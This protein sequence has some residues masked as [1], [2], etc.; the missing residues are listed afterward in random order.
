MGYI[1]NLSTVNSTNIIYQ[2][3]EAFIKKF[4]TNELLRGTLLF[5]GFG[6]LY[7]LF[8]LFIEYFLWLQPAARTFLFWTFVGVEVYLFSRF[9]AFPLFKLFK[10]QKGIS[11]RE[12]STIIGNHFPEVKDK[13]LNYIQLSQNTVDQSE[14]LLASI[15]QKSDNLAPIPFGKAINFKSNKR[16]LP[17]A[18]I[19]LL[20]LFAFFVSGNSTIISQSLDRVIHYKA[21]FVKPAPFQLVI[22]NRNL[23]VQENKDFVLSVKT[24]GAVLPENVMLTIGDESYFMENSGPG[25]FQYKFVAPSSDVVFHLEANV[26]VSPSFTLKVIDVPSISSFEMFLHFP[27][28]LN[29]KS[30]VVKGTGNAVIPEGT[31]VNWKIVSSS[32]ESIVFNEA[33]VP[34]SFVSQSNIFNF[35]KIINQNTDYQVIT[36][37]SNVKYF[38][39]LNYQLAIV[40]DQYPT[41]DVEQAPDSLKVDKRFF[42]GKIGDDY[43]FSKLQIVYYEKGKPFTSKRGTLP[44]KSGN[45]DQ[46]VFSFPGNLP[47]R[48]GISYDFYFEIFDNDA[49]HHF[50]STRSIVFSNRVSTASEKEDALIEEQNSTL[51]S[52]EKTLQKQSKQFSDLDKLNKS[53]KEK[54]ELEFKDQQMVNDFIKRQSQQDQLMKSFSEKIKEN[55][56]QDNSQNKDKTKE[57]LEKRLDKVTSAIDKNKQLLDELKELND[58]LNNEDL[59]DKLQQFKQNSKNQVKT[60]EQ[61]VELTKRYY[62]DKKA[63]QIAEKL[64]KLSNEQNK[65]SKDPATESK[66][67]DKINDEFKSLEE[68]LNDVLKENKSLKS[69]MDLP[70]TKDLQQDI[71]QDLNSAKE[72]LGKRN[73]SKAQSSQKNAS[74]KMKKMSDKLKE[75]MASGEQEQLQEDIKMLRQ[76]LDNLLAFSNSQEDVMKQFKSTKVGSSTYNKYLK[77]QQTLKTQFKHVDDSLFAMSLRNPKIAE[78][79][80]KEIGTVQYNLDNAIDKLGNGIV[81]K[82][83]S[84]QQFSV[85]SA[86]KLADF[87]SEQ[88]NNMQMD[89][90]GMSSG[91]P[92]PGHG[93]G[94]Q[95]PDIM[96]KQKGL[97]EK[98]QQQ[99][100]GEG[101]SK[102]GSKPGNKPDSKYTQG[103]EG[104]GGEGDAKSIMEIYKEQKQL[105]DALQNELNKNGLNGVGQNALEQMKQ[106]EKQLLNK[107]FKNEVLQRILNLNQE[108][109][110]LDNALQQ[111]G[112]DTKRQSETNLKGFNN[113]SKGL[114][115]NLLQYINSVEIL[116]RQSLPLR[117]NF[118]QK[119]QEYFNKND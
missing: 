10:L 113:T 49:V 62:V 41:I 33:R 78:D 79:V 114:P 108:L 118:N 23:V 44:S 5:I 97:G 112:Q 107:G 38:E 74:Q 111:Q 37:N 36:S 21:S 67:Q 91:N 105:R 9:I 72:Q 34:S 58:K 119:V 52:L 39:K 73:S 76:I 101:K 45:F 86:N 29:R 100:K 106:I 61:L 20:F 7:F 28:Y 11:Y 93:K 32:T 24:I 99:M 22:Q 17:I 95:L 110:K 31:L 117:S 94:M 25:Q 16:Y 109:L 115:N 2:K 6:L 71:K 68:Q 19:P 26:V 55:L 35:K 64:D 77:T 98:M 43:G 46:F 102:G 15:Q 59:Q 88:L 40:K 103:E 47:L 92:K 83:V 104:P 90:S 14:L 30:E 56:N 70:N 54:K 82:G 66:E 57:T 42:I 48:A 12:A 80:T 3:L 96:S 50:K 1:N 18:L 116:N 13:L 27:S 89:L 8:T 87:L 65:L 75:A 53:S 69:P 84:H 85:S 81:S 51:N 4:Y 63:T 60:L